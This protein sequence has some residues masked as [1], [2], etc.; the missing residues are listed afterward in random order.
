MAFAFLVFIMC[1]QIYHGEH[2]IVLEIGQ[3]PNMTTK[4][5]IKDYTLF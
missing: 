1:D 2:W 4:P 5:T 3:V